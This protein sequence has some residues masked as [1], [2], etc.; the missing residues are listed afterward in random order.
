VLQCIQ[1]QVRHARRVIVI[2]DTKYAALVLEFI[3]HLGVPQV[4]LYSIV[5]RFGEAMDKAVRVLVK[6]QKF[7]NLF[8]TV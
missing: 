4:T 6:R 8:F 2:E 5:F 1:S 7:A 3:H